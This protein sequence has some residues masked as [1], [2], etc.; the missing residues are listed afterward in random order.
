[1]SMPKSGS[2]VAAVGRGLRVV[3]RVLLAG[4]IALVVAFLV[5]L[6]MPVWYPPGNA[7]IDHLVMP[8]VVFPLIWAGLFFHACLDRRL[9]RVC[10]ILLVLGAGNLVMILQRLG[11]LS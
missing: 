4:P 1:M 2:R 9:V 11:F 6:A 10:A 7:D 5:M 8:M 3:L